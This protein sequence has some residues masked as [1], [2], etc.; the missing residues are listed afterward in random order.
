MNRLY[1]KLALFSIRHWKKII[2]WWLALAAVSVCFAAQLPQVLGDH[3]LEANGSYRQA[4]ASL[5]RAFRIPD[6]PVFLLFANKRGADERAFHASISDVLHRVDRISGVDVAASP[7]E[8]EGLEKGGYAY[9]MLSVPGS[10][11]DKRRAIEK[12]RSAAAGERGGVSVQLTGKPVVQEDVNRSSKQ[13]LKSA[14]TLGIPV[15]FA[16]ML[17]TFGGVRP[18]LIPLIAGG[19]SV[20]I[21]M[22]VVYAIGV[23]GD[24]SLSV[25]VYNV[26]PMAGMAVSLDFALL[27]V[28]RF[29]EERASSSV[30]QAV[31]QTMVTSGKAVTVSAFCV[32]LALLGTFY[33]RMPIFNTVALGAIAV[34]AVSALANMTFVPALLYAWGDRIAPGQA[35]LQGSGDGWLRLTAAVMKRPGMLAGA[36]MLVLL[37]LLAPVREMRLSIPGPQSLP[38]GAESRTAAETISGLFQPPSLSQVYLLVDGRAKTGDIRAELA[39]DPLVAHL[40]AAPSPFGED[41][42]LLS[43]WLRGGEA[44]PKVMQWVRDQELLRGKDGVLLGG[45]PKYEQEVHDA[46]F[47]RLPDVLAFVVVSHF[48]LLAVAFRSILIPVKA[49]LMNMLS[50]GA[51]FGILVW[52]FQEGRWGLEPADIAVMIPVFLFGLVFGISMDYGIFLLSRIDESYRNTGNVALA[53][54]D[55]LSASGKII[56]SAAAIMIAVTGP[57][58]LAG[59]SGVKQLGIGIAAALFIDATL[60]RLV[61]VPALMQLFGKWNWWRPFAKG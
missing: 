22:A 37:L 29:R 4:Q 36:S 43:A 21:A 55:G 54:R 2:G 59:V 25:F 10:I 9:A 23:M 57:F 39:Q 53:I 51:S 41:V 52:L 56:T 15:A 24:V 8:Q 26:I 7:L 48:L 20:A 12:I 19:M 14:E 60:V 17:L 44:S 27:M 31:C 28:S 45:Q 40:S 42:Y 32:L 33:I 1:V 46:I 18:A 49:I 11:S 38:P 34:L 61:L 6:E 50:L 58:A 30:R 16:I 5:E 35:R 47:S 13:D 3:G